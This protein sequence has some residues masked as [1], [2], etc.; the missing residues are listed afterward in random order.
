LSFGGVL[1]GTSWGLPDDSIGVAGVV[2]GL[3]VSHREF[4]EAGG[5]GI[6]AGDCQL[7]YSNEKILETYY[8]YSL[9]KCSG[10]TLDYQFFDDPGYNG[11]V[12]RCWSSRALPRP[13]L[14]VCDQ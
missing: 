12:D 2:N 11:I 4:L 9:N 3:S 5:L 6:N 1:K 10:V 8:T 14:S 13:V 7:N